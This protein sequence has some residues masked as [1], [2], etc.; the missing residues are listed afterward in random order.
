MANSL[1]E[2]YL[3]LKASP[4]LTDE[5]FGPI[6]TVL[7][8]AANIPTTDSK[9]PLIIVVPKGGNYLPATGYNNQTVP[10]QRRNISGI[11]ENV[12]LWLWAA[13]TLNPNIPEDNCDAIESLRER[14]L[15]AMGRQR[16]TGLYWV[17]QNETWQLVNN[18]TSLYGAGLV[19]TLQAEITVPDV[20]PLTVRIEQYELEEVIIEHI[21]V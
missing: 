21:N 3:S 13:D 18:T 17:P 12:E 6:V 16:W 9:L 19:I 11:K 8:G 2:L 5:Q 15:Q 20:A 14:L 1:K 4:I 10:Q 7:F